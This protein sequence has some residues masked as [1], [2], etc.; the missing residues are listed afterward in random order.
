MSVCDFVCSCCRRVCVRV[1]ARVCEMSFVF[2]LLD[3]CSVLMMCFVFLCAFD[4][5]G[6]FCDLFLMIVFVF[7]VACLLLTCR[8]SDV[9]DVV[10]DVV[11]VV[12][13]VVVIWARGW[14]RGRAST[15][16]E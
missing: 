13:V 5:C 3:F 2:P 16:I 12:V 1:R 6:G 9:V 15:C 14:G 8:V 4:F 10:V 7:G 11:V